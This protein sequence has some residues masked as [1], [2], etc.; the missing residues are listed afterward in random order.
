MVLLGQLLHI[1]ERVEI[2]VASTEEA[3]CVHKTLVARST[4]VRMLIEYDNLF[5]VLSLCILILPPRMLVLTGNPMVN[6]EESQN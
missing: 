6:S 1:V 2:M 3:I 4:R 5:H